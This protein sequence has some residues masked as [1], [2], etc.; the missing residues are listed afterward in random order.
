LI[1]LFANPFVF[2][3]D[4]GWG[5][6][7]VSKYVK[8][9]KQVLVRFAVFILCCDAFSNQT[10]PW[11]NT[12]FARL[13]LQ[14]GFFL[15]SLKGWKCGYSCSYRLRYSVYKGNFFK[16]PEPTSRR[17]PPTEHTYVATCTYT[18]WET[19]KSRSC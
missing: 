9:L 17:R 10:M 8:L 18:C 11:C 3:F 14:T 13:Q 7:K 6:M 16:T 19:L 4:R 1:L 5:D 15:K 2:R 12:S